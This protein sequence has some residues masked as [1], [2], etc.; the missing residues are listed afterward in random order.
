MAKVSS[1]EL[2][3]T[4]DR[5]EARLGQFNAPIVRSLYVAYIGL[6]SRFAEDLTDERDQLLSR[7]A[8]LML[9]QEIASEATDD[10]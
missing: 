10:S 1:E 5:M 7:A 3:Q 6:I 8:A 2:K 4:V 9:I